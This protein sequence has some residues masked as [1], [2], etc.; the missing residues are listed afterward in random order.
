[1]PT[2]SPHA[3][4]AALALFAAG[5]A[6]EATD[7]GVDTDTDVVPSADDA[8][9]EAYDIAPPDAATQTQLMGT[10]YL[11]PEQVCVPAADVPNL[12]ASAVLITID[13]V[14]HVCVWDA[15]SGNVPEGLAFT[16]LLTCDIA[17]TQGPSW[18][19]KPARIHTSPD[20]LLDD[21]AF[22]A[23]LDWVQ[24]Q[25]EASGC[26]CC[27]AS[28]VGSGHTT[29]FD[30][31]APGVWT[32]TMTNAQ[33]IMASG[34]FLDHTLFG[35][36]EA[37]DNQG[38]DRIQTLFASTDSA[39]MK[40]FFEDEF[41]RREGSQADRDDAEDQFTALFGRL[42]DDVA[43]CISPF[44]GIE[45]GKLVWNG[46]PVRQIYVLPEAS[47][48]P[49]FTPNLDLPQDT[50]W[51]LYVEPTGNPIASGTLSVGDI[52]TGTQQMIPADDE[53]PTLV[54]GTT[55]RLYATL[56]IMVQPQLDCTFVYAAP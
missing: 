47:P 43:A 42:F 45:D 15:F 9:W 53:A 3:L 16:D 32:D 21:P 2:R 19:S 20:V 56:D 44:E 30:V 40:A 25:I 1:M 4:L 12:P 24:A 52:P 6:T 49:G 34:A 46:Q 5:C 23:E 31:S 35:H 54:G 37:S 29:G 10:P 55:Y 36:Y 26:A 38:F 28:G 13:E 22:V 14:D 39:R 17:F 8:A 18:F 33:L 7:T 11:W 50:V 51:A 48:T 27:H 41:D